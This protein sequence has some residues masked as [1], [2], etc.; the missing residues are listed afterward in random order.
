MEI[1]KHYIGIPVLAAAHLAVTF[2]T[3]QRVFAVPASENLT[4]YIIC[5]GIAFA[6]LLAFYY[7]LYLLLFSG[8]GTKAP[9]TGQI[10]PASSQ[11]APG[12][13][14]DRTAGLSDREQER[15]ETLKE[16]LLCAAPYLVVVALVAFFKLRQGYLSNDELLIYQNA[17]TLTHYT[18]FTYIT[19][20]FYIVA[21]ML[22]PFMY[23]PIFFKLIIELLV[24][25]YV[26]MRIR[27]HYGRVYGYASYL[28]FLLYPV[29]AYTT[30]AHRLPVY[31][32]VYLYLMTKLLF[33]HMEKRPVSIPGLIWI[34]FLSAILTQWRTEG[35]Y[36]AVL[37][38]ILIFIT[39]LS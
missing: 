28:L 14:A 8:S 10:E 1:R 32:L 37:S 15:A 6:V 29:L 31:F 23:G 26:V 21:L 30:S 35:I 4:D 33:D 11:A 27:R 17:V 3:D 38:L 20:Y 22:L 7:G 19:V 39:Y 25:G 12:A 24:V 9:V 34:L 2:F 5:K 13:S 18:W 16:V 36:F